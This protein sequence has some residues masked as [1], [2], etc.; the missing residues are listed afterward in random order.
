MYKR[1]I[2][3]LDIEAKSPYDEYNKFVYKKLI[4]VQDQGEY[5]PGIQDSDKDMSWCKRMIEWDSNGCP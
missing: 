4:D 1:Q 5:Q 3:D 2:T